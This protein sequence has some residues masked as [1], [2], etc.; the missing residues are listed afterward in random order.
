MWF[1]MSGDNLFVPREEALRVG[2]FLLALSFFLP[3]LLMITSEDS[4]FSV[5]WMIYAPIWVLQGYSSLLAG[6][7]H[8]FAILMFQFWLPYTL[9]GYQAYRYASGRLS[10]ERRYFQSILIL[11]VIA[12]LLVLPISLMPSGSSYDGVTYTYH[13]SPYIPIPIFSI[14]AAASYRLLRPT[15][16]E[17]PWTDESE[18]VD[19]TLDEESI[20]AD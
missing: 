5:D 6:G 9:I 10:S 7:P 14:L 19:S 13:Y 18:S 8:P 4:L 12:I 2:K 16:V 1:G 20:W 11:T 15:K 3:Y 17:V